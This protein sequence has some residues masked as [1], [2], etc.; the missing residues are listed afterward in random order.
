MA[1]SDADVGGLIALQ[2]ES[3]ARAGAGL[4]GSWPPAQAMGAERLGEFLGA[5][6]Y[7]ILATARP[8][9]RPQ[10]APISFLV[11]D[12]GFWFATV[13]GARLRNLRANPYASF[14]VSDGEDG[15]HRAVMAE[16]SMKLH[17]PTDRLV[18]EWAER[19]GSDPTW[20]AAMLE[21]VPERLFS[22]AAACPATR[23]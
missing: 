11:R 5:R 13:A 1:V 9:G 19:H 6:R 21:L 23:A 17:E 10:A 15:A 2:D 22:Y 3:Y 8:D 4:R 7:G 12:G 20:A 14:V 18:A 16:G